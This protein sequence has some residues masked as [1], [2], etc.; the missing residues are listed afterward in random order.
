M[1]RQGTRPHCGQTRSILG[2]GRARCFCGTLALE[3]GTEPSG[4][5]STNANASQPKRSFRRLRFAA[6][7]GRSRGSSAVL[8]STK[9]EAAHPKRLLRRPS[10]TLLGSMPVTTVGWLQLSSLFSPMSV[11]YC[12]E[13]LHLRTHV[14]S[15]LLAQPTSRLL[16][17][18]AM[19]SLHGDARSAVVA[20]K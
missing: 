18:R 8:A 13:S 10:L 7:A 2:D 20:G 3:A 9:L 5:G 6:S 11:M 1:A 4:S 16:P 15:S 17:R 12:S 14:S 19:L